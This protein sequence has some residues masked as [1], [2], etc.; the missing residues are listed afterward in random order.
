MRRATV[1]QVEITCV[2]RSF[3]ELHESPSLEWVL[4]PG[5]MNQ[6]LGGRAQ[7]AG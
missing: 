6:S 3:E 4:A 7:L 5:E 2:F 1:G